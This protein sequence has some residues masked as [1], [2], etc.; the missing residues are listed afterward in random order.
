M[1]VS[2]SYD[3]YEIDLSKP[4]EW[5]ERRIIGDYIGVLKCDGKIYIKLDSQTNDPIPLH[6]TPIIKTREGS[7]FEKIYFYVPSGQSG[8]CVIIVGRELGLEAQ[9]FMS[10]IVK[11]FIY[12]KDENMINPATEETLN[13]FM[14]KKFMNKHKVLDIDLGTARTDEVIAT[15][16]SGFIILSRSA[17]A[18][19][20]IKLG[21]NSDYLTQDDLKDHEGIT[22][23]ELSDLIITNSAQSGESV[24][25]LAFVRE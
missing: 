17:N 4:A 18:T 21:A 9:P 7:K 8:E 12:D 11:A 3:V 1:S 5:V 14:Q 13:S 16:C 25:I 15:N 20:Q 19:F 24:K 23:F 10:N 2:K 6:L 22:E